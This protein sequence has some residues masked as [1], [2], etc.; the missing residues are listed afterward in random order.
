MRAKE[1]IAE[2]RNNLSPTAKSALSRMVVMPDMDMFYEYYRFMTMTA[3]E[4]EE[5]I[6]P[7]GKLRDNP[8]ALPYTDAEMTMIKNA[9]SRMGRKVS[10]ITDSGRE[11]DGTNTT[12]PVSKP[13]KNRYGI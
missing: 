1:F 7:T 2:D 6:P 9:A 3:G 13:K 10:E 8:V 12:S 11:L 5:K 4:P